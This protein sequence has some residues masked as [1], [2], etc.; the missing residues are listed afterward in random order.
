MDV[1]AKLR[2]LHIAPRK[3][4]L[5]IDGIRGLNVSEAL[6]RLDF[7]NRRAAKPMTKL[8]NSAIANAEH[9]FNLERD[10]LYIKEI[11]ADE[12]PKFKRWQPRAFGRAYPVLKRTSHVS[13][14]LDGKVLS[15]AK[16]KAPPEAPEEKKVSP[17]KTGRP[18]DFKKLARSQGKSSRKQG[19][20]IWDPRRPAGRRHQEHADKELLEKQKRLD[21]FKKFFRRKS[22]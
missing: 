21:R 10:T 9:N 5:V 12:G 3:V 19:A 8:L 1:R 2:H 14:V 15:R 11:R 20:K 18:L 6:S 7:D 13:I 4:R 16:R 17:K 22:G